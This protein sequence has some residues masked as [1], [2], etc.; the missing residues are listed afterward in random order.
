MLTPEYL[1]QIS[2]SDSTVYLNTS[3]RVTLIDRYWLLK[4]LSKQKIN[5]ISTPL[6]VRGKST[7]RYKFSEFLV[8]YLNV[9]GKNNVG[10]LVYTLL[11]YEIYF[12]EGLS[13]NSLISNNIISHKIIVINLGKITTLIGVCKVIINVNT[14]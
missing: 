11:Q 5:I 7:S 3:C 2:D 10:D 8:L 13:D 1:L 14:K 6:K 4:H 12:V 9:P